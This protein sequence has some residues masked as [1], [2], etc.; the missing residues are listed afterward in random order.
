MKNADRNS[1][2]PFSD[3]MPYQQHS[4]V[5]KANE[6]VRKEKSEKKNFKRKHG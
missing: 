6:K 2:N 3:K 1:Y 5:Y 4:G